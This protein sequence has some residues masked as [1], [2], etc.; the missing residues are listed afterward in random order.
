MD[1]TTRDIAYVT[2]GLM[3]I[4]IISLLHEGLALTLMVT[5]GAVYIYFVML[6]KKHQESFAQGDTVIMCKNCGLI[7][8]EEP[9]SNTAD[10]NFDIETL[11][12][13]KCEVYLTDNVKECDDGMYDKDTQDLM[14]ELN[15]LEK[16]PSTNVAQIQSIKRVLQ[17]LP[18]VPNKQ[19][20][21]TM[22]DWVQPYH[23]SLPVIK[24]MPKDYMARGNPR[25]W[26]YCY[27]PMDTDNGLESLKKQLEGNT[28]RV[29]ET[30]VR[31]G[32][33]QKLSNGIQNQ[34]IE[35]TDLSPRR[36]RQTYCNLFTSGDNV[37]SY[38]KT[39][40]S[41]AQNKF[42][43]MDLTQNG[44]IRNIQIYR[45]NE[46]YLTLV[47]NWQKET[48]STMQDD[49]SLISTF[50]PKMEETPER[51]NIETAYYCGDKILRKER[52]IYHQLLRDL[53]EEVVEGSSVYLRLKQSV[54]VLSFKFNICVRVDKL[55]PISMVT[56]SDI[57]GNAAQRTTLLHPSAGR[58]QSH[59]MDEKTL[60]RSGVCKIAIEM[61]K[62]YEKL[63]KTYADQKE[64]A[65]KY[66][67]KVLSGSR[68]K[69]AANS[70][71]M[72][73]KLRIEQHEYESE[74]SQMSK[75][76][77]GMVKRIQKINNQL[78]DMEN[79]TETIITTMMSNIRGKQITNN[80]NN[81]KSSDGRIYF[82]AE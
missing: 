30:V 14:Q 36:I 9:I 37:K 50:D 11:P 40:N 69:M 62:V 64:Y 22:G 70:T 20:K 29:G 45:W 19:C 23:P 57:L 15:E 48:V 65:K 52:S 75:E 74:L 16:S 51:F 8:K 72:M 63:Q 82:K 1:K 26:A 34:R 4:Y 79:K 31:S 53:Y 3:C 44:V 6:R 2:I 5:L 67:D 71:N 25:H 17:D 46:G 58:I 41:P 35:F 12:L 77:A 10:Y 24:A 13:K 21:L 7:P 55:N 18:R 54:N 28:I 59:L 38:Y 78:M 80:F 81:L 73:V 68:A 61:N 66:Q 60:E 27:S 39:F 33:N 43:C 42:F 47:P 49:V 56:L 32:Y 76:K